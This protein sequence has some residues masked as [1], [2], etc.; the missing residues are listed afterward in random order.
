MQNRQLDLFQQPQAR[1]D[2]C[3]R[4]SKRARRLSIQVSESKGVEVVVPP[5]T[6]PHAVRQFVEANRDWIQHARDELDVSGPPP[7]LFLPDRIALCINSEAYSAS[8]GHKTPRNGWRETGPCRLELSCQRASYS[9]GRRVLR[10]WLRHKGRE[11]LIPRLAQQAQAMNMSY[12][13]VQVRGQRTRWGSYSSTGTL[14][15]NYC[16]LFVPADLADYLFIHE[17]CHTRHM[18]HSARF[19]QLV[20]RFAPNYREQEKRL[21]DGRRYLPDWLKDDQ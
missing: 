6:R 2:I 20:S 8:Y 9:A 13:Q 18:N 17:L 1:P 19:W 14:S 4:E 11:I 5:R 15:I 3:I 21:N 16:L 10:E 12:R 7:L